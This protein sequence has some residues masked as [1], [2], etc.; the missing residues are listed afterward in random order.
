M[1]DQLL[2]DSEIF[3]TAYRLW[4]FRF[5]LGDPLICTVH[6]RS[7]VQKLCCW[8]FFLAGVFLLLTTLGALNPFYRALQEELINQILPRYL[9]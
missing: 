1:R 8:E 4:N 3:E 5:R 6:I 7:P 9:F 2:T